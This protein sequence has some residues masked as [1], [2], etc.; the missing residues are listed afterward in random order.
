MNGFLKEKPITVFHDLY[1]VTLGSSAVYMYEVE[2]RQ[3]AKKPKST[4]TI[5]IRP[6]AFRP[7]FSMG[8]A[9]FD[10]LCAISPPSGIRPREATF[11]AFEA[12]QFHGDLKKQ[13]R[14]SFWQD[15]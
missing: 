2:H 12:I 15:L 13:E 7:H 10:W 6:A 1:D 14:H 9:L 4:I 3:A 11:R 8:M 5:A